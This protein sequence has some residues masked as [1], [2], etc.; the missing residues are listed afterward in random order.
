MKLKD[1]DEEIMDLDEEKNSQK[2][3]CAD[4]CEE[5]ALLFKDM[6]L[7]QRCG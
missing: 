2:D 6:A 3:D 1:F 7:W 5:D 4:E